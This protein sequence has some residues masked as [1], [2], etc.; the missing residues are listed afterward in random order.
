MIR[1]L[2]LALAAIVAVAALCFG[3]T[4]M[5]PLVP[6]QPTPVLATGA[7][8]GAEPG[9]APAAAAVAAP[10]GP[11]IMRINGEPVTEEEFLLFISTLPDNVKQMASQTEARK[12]IAEQFVRM[13][14]LEQEGRRL[15]ADKDPDVASKMQF[16]HTNV[17]VEYALKKIAA[18]PPEPML[19][20]E[21]EKHKTEFQST[22]LSHILVA[23]EGGQI[24]PKSG[25][26][27]PIQQAAQKAQAIEAKLRSGSL[28]GPMAAQFSDDQTTGVQGGKLGKVQ[29]G[30]LPPEIQA[31]V[32]KL[33]PG[34]ISQPV[35]SQFGI[36]IFRVDDRQ[37]SAYE[38]V[39]PLIMRKVQQDMVTAAVDK[40][41]KSARVERDPKYFSAKAPLVQPKPQG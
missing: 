15:G 17:V 16:G 31:V 28:F 26:A 24:P 3:A 41:E 32:D 2:S 21:Y 6:P 8:A 25:P 9:V 34:E 19:R 35:R 33:K 4:K 38:Q 39:R 37:G 14:V 5:H 12:K 1:D 40:L 29:P 23:Y 7:M 13:K 20:A 27:L 22:E 10:S 11:V 36:H 18:T 30:M